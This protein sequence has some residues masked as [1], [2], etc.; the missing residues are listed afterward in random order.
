MNKIDNIIVMIEM[1]EMTENTTEIIL[2]DDE[3]YSD[4]NWDWIKTLNSKETSN[5]KD[6]IIKKYHTCDSQLEK[7]KHMEICVKNISAHES[8]K[9]YFKKTDFTKR[10][11]HFYKKINNFLCAG[12]LQNNTCHCRN[13]L[14]WNLM[15]LRVYDRKKEILS[16][17]DDHN[18]RLYM[19]E[20]ERED[21][22]DMFC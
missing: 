10:K 4:F 8:L 12:G 18:E 7:K 17:L 14:I 16:M 5:L 13:I 20:C 3:N 11:Y 19:N 15:I 22:R 9:S 1:T 2:F 21:Y 6:Q